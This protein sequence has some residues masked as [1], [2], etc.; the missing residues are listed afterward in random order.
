MPKRIDLEIGS[1][2]SKLTI[3]GWSKERGKWECLCDCN[4]TMYAFTHP[5]RIG[6]AKSCGCL[7]HEKDNPLK[8]EIQKNIKVGARFGK[9]TALEWVKNKAR[10]SCQCDC[11]NK[12]LVSSFNLNSN[13]IK[14]C[15][16]A[17]PKKRFK[18]LPN[19]LGIKNRLLR[20]CKRSAK[21]RGHSFCLTKKLFFEKIV[22]NCDYCGVNPQTKSKI[23]VYKN[24]NFKYNGIDRVDNSIGYLDFNIVPC[25]KN[26]NKAK[27]S[28]SLDQFYDLV[29]RNY[30][31]ILEKEE[32][33]L[34]K[35][36]CI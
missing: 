8:K 22:E 14:S 9:L 28:L 34:S 19:A 27:A 36:Y 26:C 5:L 15:G 33:E 11:L 24:D 4:N 13:I 30:N 29:K 17:E 3:V 1:K 18:K 21:K 35:S 2:F 32:Q 16:C 6:R 31:R 23:K 12:T 20:I 7:H 25:C 10:W